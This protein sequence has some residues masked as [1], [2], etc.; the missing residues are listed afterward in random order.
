MLS[1][2]RATGWGDGIF[3]RRSALLRNYDAFG[4]IG[5][6]FR[7]LDWKILFFFWESGAEISKRIV[8]TVRRGGLR[9]VGFRQPLLAHNLA[10]HGPLPTPT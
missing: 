3:A 5:T 6:T 7:E 4:D 2:E 8:V 10:S 9:P 1:R